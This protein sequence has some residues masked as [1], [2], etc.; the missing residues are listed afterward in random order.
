MAS[1]AV[2]KAFMGALVEGDRLRSR[3]LI[4]QVLE[5][6]VPAR[7]VY[8]EFLWPAMEQVAAWYKDD[9]INTAS[10]HMATR[11]LRA[12]TD[13]LQIHLAQRE[14]NGKRV[15][16]TCADGEP[17]E[18]GAQV[19]AD[20]FEAEGWE[21]YFVGGGVPQDEILALVGQLRPD[22][23]LVFG[24]QPS[25]VVGVR[26]LVQM[27]RE[28]GAHPTMNILISGGVFNRAEGLWE[29]VHADLFAPTAREA[30]SV[31][32]K[33]SP[34]AVEAEVRTGTK[35]RRRRRRPP[36]LVQAEAEKALVGSGSRSRL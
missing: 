5:E 30:L 24:T 15:L 16:V 1:G 26:N 6:G 17:E 35:K 2:F 19:C 31:A 20:Y 8:D 12:I 4:Q 28:V 29:E 10:E 13:Q 18:M 25:G 34:R 21:A 33:A 11:I 3:E 9:R 36:L 27:I 14:R 22:I 32:G 23:L 7:R